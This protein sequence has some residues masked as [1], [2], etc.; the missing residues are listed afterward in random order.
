MRLMAFL[1]T[2]LVALAPTLCTA[3]ASDRVITKEIALKAIVIFRDDPLSKEGRAAAAL[4]VTFID[5]NHDVVVELNKKAF[6]VFDAPGVSQD[7]RALLLAAFAAG[8]ADSQ[9]LRG[10]R[11]DDSYAGDLQLIQTYRQLQR[12][13]VKLKIPSIEKMAQM[14]QRG[15]LKRYLNSK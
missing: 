4:I 5:K 6:P 8:N 11:K 12:N 15:E 2:G 10:V 14:E 1:L 13:N 7:E 9:L 3:A